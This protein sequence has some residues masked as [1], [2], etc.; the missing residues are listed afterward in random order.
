V[1]SAARTSYHVYFP[2][3]AGDVLVVVNELQDP[4]ALSEAIARL[5]R[6]EPD[7]RIHVLAP[8]QTPSG[9]ARS[10]LR[11]VNVGKVLRATGEREIEVLSGLLEAAG[12]AHQRHVEVGPWL[13]TIAS[14]VR[15]RGCK[16]IFIG[17]NAGSFLKNLLLRHDCSL[18]RAYLARQGISCRVMR[19]E[20]TVGERGAA[21]EGT[22][23]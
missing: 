15:D 16:R 23:A 13:E 6:A 14:F 2:A 8:Q 9:Y 5:H 20:E 12:V 3:G 1:V 19:R 10:H 7:T 22:G 17:D 18:L 11:R 4:K 21:T